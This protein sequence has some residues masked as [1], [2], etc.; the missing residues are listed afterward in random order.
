MNGE[1][2]VSDDVTNHRPYVQCAITDPYG[3]APYGTAAV[4]IVLSVTQVR[5]L[6]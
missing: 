2:S 1:N 6:R 4:E 3:I 5:C